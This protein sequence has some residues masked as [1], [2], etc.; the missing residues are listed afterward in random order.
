MKRRCVA[1]GLTL[2]QGSARILVSALTGI[3]QDRYKDSS[4]D[5]MRALWELRVS[6]LRLRSCLSTFREVA[7]RADF[8]LKVL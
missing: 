6:G 2:G 3:L 5:A 4:T 1:A 7:I 8:F